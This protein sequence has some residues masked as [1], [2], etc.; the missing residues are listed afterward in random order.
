M[1]FKAITYFS[2]CTFK[3]KI[4]N[5]K[6]NFTTGRFAPAADCCWWCLD[7][8]CSYGGWWCG[9][10]W[11]LQLALTWRN[12]G[13]SRYQ[14]A[15]GPQWPPASSA[16]LTTQTKFVIYMKK[17]KEM[18]VFKQDSD[19]LKR[20]WS[21][22]TVGATQKIRQHLHKAGPLCTLHIDPQFFHS[23]SVLRPRPKPALSIR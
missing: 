17:V 4:I 10:P 11:Q 23:T 6:Y 7:K 3:S 18:L 13:H 22:D 20:L 16:L 9:V 15:C 14:L 12:R 19:V 21:E 8:A 2:Q 1:S 5:Q